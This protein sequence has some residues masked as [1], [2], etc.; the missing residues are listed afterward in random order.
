MLSITTIPRPFHPILVFS[1][2]VDVSDFPLHHLVVRPYFIVSVVFYLMV[3]VTS[4]GF[5]FVKGGGFACPLLLV[6][7]VHEIALRFSFRP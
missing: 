5:G 2:L 6:Y 7:K 1:L 4:F 3:E